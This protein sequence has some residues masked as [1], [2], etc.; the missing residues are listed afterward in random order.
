M[1]PSDS[2]LCITSA[3]KD[4]VHGRSGPLNPRRGEIRRCRDGRFKSRGWTSKAQW[5]HVSVEELHQPCLLPISRPNLFDFVWRTC[6]GRVIFA[7]IVCLMC[8]HFLMSYVSTWVLFLPFPRFALL[9]F[10]ASCL[11]SD[12][13]C[14]A[15]WLGSIQRIPEGLR[16]GSR[17]SLR[18]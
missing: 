1:H 5:Y 8:A 7:M 2:I 14:L 13:V 17:V 3:G 16:D 11:S 9:I 15:L 18:L 10:K 6:N 4:F 12:A